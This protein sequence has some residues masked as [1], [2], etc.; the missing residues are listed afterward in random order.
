MA[1]LQR[2][3]FLDRDGTLNVEKNYVYR[4]E[5]FELIPGTAEALRLLRKY[6]YTII[7]VSNQSGVARGFYTMNDVQ[8]LEN[9][10]REILAKDHATVDAFFYCPH[11]PEG[12][13]PA[14]SVDC[15]CRKPK[16]GLFYRANALFPADLSHSWMIGDSLRDTEFGINAGLRPVLVRTGYGTETEKIITE[17]KISVE[18]ITDDFF[19]AALYIISMNYS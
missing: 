8:R 12:K 17:R 10:L 9:Y 11:H 18:T 19:A 4:P 3:V 14:F 2:V 16:T 5:D 13:V 1:T 15:D 7:V 6:G